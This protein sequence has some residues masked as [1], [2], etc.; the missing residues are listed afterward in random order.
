MA[1]GFS[2]KLNEH[3]LRQIKRYTYGVFRHDIIDVIIK[4]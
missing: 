1:N 4:P 3:N 2:L